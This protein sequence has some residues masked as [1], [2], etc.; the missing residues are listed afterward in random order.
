MCVCGCVCGCLHSFTVMFVFLLQKKQ[1]KVV[2]V[3]RKLE[4]S[5][6]IVVPGRVRKD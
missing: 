1:A 4:G 6:D 3:A 2:E 5:V